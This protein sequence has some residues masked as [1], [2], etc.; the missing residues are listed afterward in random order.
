MENQ[1]GI[2]PQGDRLLIKPEDIE[3]T[4]E[5][6]IVIPDTIGDQHA[7]AQSIG[8]L[9][10]IGPDCWIDHIERDGNGRVTKITGYTG[11]FADVGD[12]VCFAKY[13]GIQVEGKDGELYRIMND[14]DITAKVDEG[15]SFTD[16][17]SRKPF[18]R[19]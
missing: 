8:T 16:L 10:A 1:S 18:S 4:T 11:A 12:R 9:V 5:G 19:S 2:Y 3:R 17:K 7:M 13:G 14:T 15:V 6:G